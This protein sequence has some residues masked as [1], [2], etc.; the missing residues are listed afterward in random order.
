MANTTRNLDIVIRVQDQATAQFARLEQQLTAFGRSVAATTQR[1]QAV[2]AHVGPGARP[3]GGGIGSVAQAQLQQ[4]RQAHQAMLQAERQAHQTSLQQARQAHQARLQA[5]RQ[6]YQEQ[7]RLARQAAQ[8]RV[9]AER[10]APREARRSDIGYGFQTGG[11][12]GGARAGATALGDMV[13]IS[14][15][16]VAGIAALGASLLVVTTNAAQTAA[17]MLNLQNRFTAATGSTAA[18]AVEFRR[19]SQLANRLGV[20]IT[21]L[22]TSYASFT[23]AARGTNLEGEKARQVFESITQASVRMGLSGEQTRGH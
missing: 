20:D 17:Q 11:L 3:I 12:L 1:T 6:A 14:A 2:V 9:R 16:A 15:G 10:E 5:D 22:G 23:A 19:V 18:G 4:A 21:A 8:E 7:V 13:G